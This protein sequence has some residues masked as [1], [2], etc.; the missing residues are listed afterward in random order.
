MQLAF[1]LFTRNPLSTPNSFSV[2]KIAYC[3]HM[4]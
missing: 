1:C 4:L 3:T 2:R